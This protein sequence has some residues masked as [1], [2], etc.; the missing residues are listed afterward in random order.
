MI[1]FA[2]ACVGL[3]LVALAFVLVPLLR[4]RQPDPG[5]Q[6]HA[7]NLAV[8]RDQLD[9]LARDLD[10][11]AIP[12]AQY[13]QAVAE[14]KA[15]LLEDVPAQDGVNRQANRR[16]PLYGVALALGVA[17][18]VAAALLYLSLGTPQALVAPPTPTA[19]ASGHSQEEAQVE[20]MVNA[21]AA[22]LESNPNDA[23]G[24]SL[25]GRT[26]AALGRFDASAQAFERAL[27][28]RPDDAQTLAD[29]AD[30]LA[31]AQGQR[32][33]GRPA[34]L[35]ERALTLDPQHPKS[36]ALAGAAAFERGDYRG[37][38]ERWER[39][40]TVMPP[41]SEIVSQ[42]DQSIAEARQRGGLASAPPIAAPAGPAAGNAHVKGVVK[43]APALTE[44]VAPGDTVFVYAR[45]AEGPPM[46]LAIVRKSA[47][48]LPLAFDLNESMTMAPGMSLAN[49]SEVV[50]TAR[51]SKSGS[52]APQSG[53]LEGVSGPVKVGQTDLEV[54]IDRVRP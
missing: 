49:F 22:K 33:A 26:Q 8:Y 45:A 46:P 42:L 10:N 9:E 35:V 4:S 52:A 21:L 48:E 34:E 5:A 38:V 17:L 31:M 6:R 20:A 37:A 44:K 41:G 14:L 51:V 15:R 11:G 16:G 1:V 7:L 29:L 25:M 30:S 2:V 43:I 19:G 23:E 12:R 24:W 36:L 54:V 32:L 27:A 39:L 18:P 3:V 53:D 47:S 40:R 13:E 28:L 50:V